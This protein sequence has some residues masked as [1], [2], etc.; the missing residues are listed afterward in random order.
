MSPN[1][2]DTLQVKNADGENVM[3]SK[4]MTMVGMGTTFS[5]IV[6]DNPAIKNT[7][8]ERAFRCIVSGLGCV[9]QFTNSY[10]SM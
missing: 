4:I 6:S 2:K 1:S 5:D 3:V 9:K 8:G 7:V 10:K